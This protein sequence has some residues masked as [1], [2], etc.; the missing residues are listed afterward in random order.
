M[1]ELQPSHYDAIKSRRQRWE[2]RPLFRYNDAGRGPS[3][4]DKLAT[5]GRV[6]ILQKGAG[7]GRVRTAETSLLRIA[8]V[9]RYTSAQDMVSE[10][11]ADLLP[12]HTDRVQVYRDL[13]GDLGC[14]GGFVA[15]RLEWPNEASAAS[16]V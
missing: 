13:Y 10:L 5:V 7:T 3:L 12:D 15:M 16:N 14:A 4:D 6:V 8:E 1:L 9:R 11:A 2:A